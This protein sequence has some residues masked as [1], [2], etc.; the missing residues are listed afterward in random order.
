[1]LSLIELYI[2]INL[3]K[4][5]EPEIIKIIEK[6]MIHT[7]KTKEEL[8][9]AV[10]MWCEKESRLEA[11]IKYGHISNWN[12][13]LIKDMSD[14]FDRKVNFN[15]DINEWDVSNVINMDG[16]F[17]DA[18]SFNQPLD[19]W[20]V[21]KVRTMEDMFYECYSF[22]QDISSWNVSNVLDMESMFY[23]ATNFNHSINNWDVSNVENSKYIFNGAICME[24]ENK[25]H[26]K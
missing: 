12:V 25:P 22:N 18:Y 5:Y 9:N 24:E 1:M 21:S 15:D 7:F 13:I 20:N 26:F 14:L 10:N 2:L 6:F 23:N 16:M 17:A 3:I 11:E 19:K 8:R 4:N